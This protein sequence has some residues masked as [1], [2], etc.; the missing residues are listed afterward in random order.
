MPGL[1]QLQRFANDIDQLGNESS[2]RAEKNETLPKLEFPTNI[3]EADDSEEFIFGLP[4][5]KD[6]TENSN[7]E[8]SNTN[9]EENLLYL[10]FV[11]KSQNH[12]KHQ[13][14]LNQKNQ[15]YHLFPE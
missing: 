14:C 12:Q 4:I 9:A 13:N 10:F 11:L 8:S 2:R 5:Q 7:I 3:S 6:A 1:K 15:N